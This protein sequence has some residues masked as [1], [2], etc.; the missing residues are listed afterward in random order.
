LAN[1]VVDENHGYSVHVEDT[2]VRVDF[3]N[4][5]GHEPAMWVPPAEIEGMHTHLARNV[6]NGLYVPVNTVHALQLQ[7]VN[8]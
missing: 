6:Q 7:G 8:I 2:V 3:N 5:G 4:S 1:K